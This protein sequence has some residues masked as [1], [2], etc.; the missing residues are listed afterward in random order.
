MKGGNEEENSQPSVH[1][2]SAPN[3]RD[4][5]VEFLFSM[6]GYGRRSM[7]REIPYLTITSFIA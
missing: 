5:T 3:R 2:V 6:I 1:L 4:R 7:V